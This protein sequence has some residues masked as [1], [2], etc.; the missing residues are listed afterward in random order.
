MFLDSKT[1]DVLLDEGTIIHDDSVQISDKETIYPKLIEKGSFL[2]KANMINFETINVEPFAP[3]IPGST[4][5]V[6]L[7]KVRWFL[8]EPDLVYGQL[9]DSNNRIIYVDF[10][11]STIRSFI[12][13]S[14]VKEID[15]LDSIDPSFLFK[16]IIDQESDTSNIGIKWD[17]SNPLCLI[18][19]QYALDA[20]FIKI[21]FYLI[22]NNNTMKHF[23][24]NLL[25]QEL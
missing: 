3:I 4:L 18:K 23:W 25:P 5:L 24:M 6:A 7:D 13:L 12:D 2:L 9:Y 1:D 21:N 16:E 8:S 14:S 19:K 10:W 15:L 17:I 22:L 11:T 20:S